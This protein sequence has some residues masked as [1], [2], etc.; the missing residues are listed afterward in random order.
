MSANHVSQGPELHTEIQRQGLGQMSQGG[1][2][3][4]SKEQ[5]GFP[6]ISIFAM[7]SFSQILTVTGHVNTKR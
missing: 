6:K 4:S 7:F 3:A 2:S 5:V 1:S